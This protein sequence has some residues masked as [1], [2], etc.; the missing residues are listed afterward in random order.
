MLPPL[1]DQAEVVFL[2]IVA[3]AIREIDDWPI[4]ELTTDRFIDRLQDI[5]EE[6]CIQ[7]LYQLE[8]LESAVRSQHA[9]LIRAVDLLR[10]PKAPPRATRH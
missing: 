9:A 8:Y 1:R 10:D 6:S 3:D 7:D 4:D 5:L 2:T